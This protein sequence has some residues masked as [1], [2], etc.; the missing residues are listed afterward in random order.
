MCG[1]DWSSLAT[2]QRD[3][4][5]SGFVRLLAQEDLKGHPDMNNLGVPLTISFAKTA[6]DR[7]VM[8]MIYS[9]NLFGRLYLIRSGV[10]ADRVAM[11]RKALADTLKDKALLAEA[12]KSGLDIKPMG[13]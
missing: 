3:W 12:E 1:M 7:Q 11:L 10:P 4:I 13:G 2:Q 5:S 9:Q 8:E 6:E